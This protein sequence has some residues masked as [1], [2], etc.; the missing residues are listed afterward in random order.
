MRI[1]A[2]QATTVTNQSITFPHSSF[3]QFCVEAPT[4]WMIGTAFRKKGKLKERGILMRIRMTQMLPQ[5][6]QRNYLDSTILYQLL[7]KLFPFLLEDLNSIKVTR[8]YL[9]CYL[10]LMHCV[11]WIIRA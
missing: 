1:T 9:V 2:C 8:K 4:I 5:K 11:H 6:L 7:I 3:S 10:L